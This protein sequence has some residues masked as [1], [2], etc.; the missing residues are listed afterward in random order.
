MSSPEFSLPIPPCVIPL[1]SRGDDEARTEEAWQLSL[2]EG[3][4]F[5]GQRF[6]LPDGCSVSAE[7]QW[8]ES[9]GQG[10]HPGGLLSVRLSLRAGVLASCARC[11]KE[12]ALAIS[13]DLMYLYYLAKDA[14]GRPE[15]GDP[16]GGGV[17]DGFMPV[18]V[19]S[20]GRTLD[21]A[22]QVWETLLL[23]LPTKVLCRED[24]AGLCPGCGADLNEVPCSCKPDAG[25]PRFEALR[26]LSPG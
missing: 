9:P 1:P 3:V 13:D 23:L 6:L 8:L 25:D 17:D 24:C 5:E 7:A 4:D 22:P 16:L 21:L 10:P 26:S 19:V 18:D 11:L 14:G 20:F 15:L 2:P 12:T